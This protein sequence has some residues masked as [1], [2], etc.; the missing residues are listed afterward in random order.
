MKAGKGL[1][2]NLIETFKKQSAV[3]KIL[4]IAFIV[5]LIYN[6]LTFSVTDICIILLGLIAI[7]KFIEWFLKKEE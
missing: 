5:A 3:V 2:M 4:N 1:K 7:V 6:I